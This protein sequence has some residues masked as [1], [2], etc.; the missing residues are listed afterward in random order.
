MRSLDSPSRP[1]S[2]FDFIEGFFQLTFE[3]ADVESDGAGAIQNRDADH[4][5]IQALARGRVFRMIE[6]I[7]VDT[8]LKHDQVAQTHHRRQIIH[9]TGVNSRW[10]ESDSA[11]FNQCDLRAVVEEQNQ[12][13]FLGF[14]MNFLFVTCQRW[15][16]WAT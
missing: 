10:R 7:M 2:P 8:L 12:I 9:W 1:G 14:R 15:F 16:V 5:E 4:N 3:I 13:S 11:W 6:Q